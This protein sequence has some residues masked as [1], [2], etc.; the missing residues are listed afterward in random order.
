MNNILVS[1]VRLGDAR[2][3]G[4]GVLRGF[5]GGVGSCF[6]YLE[7]VCLGVE[8]VVIFAV[9]VDLEDGVWGVDEVTIMRK[10]MSVSPLL[11]LSDVASP[12]LTCTSGLLRTRTILGSS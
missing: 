7:R 3:E 1:G 4:G 11:L 9:V 5:H 6:I 10:G 8:D 2:G 12:R